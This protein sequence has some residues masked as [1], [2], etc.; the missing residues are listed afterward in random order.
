LSTTFENLID[1]TLAE[2][3]GQTSDLEQVTFLTANINA[4]DLTLSVDDAS[5]VSRGLIEIDDELM[6]V[7]RVDPTANQVYIAPF[8][9]GYRSTTAATHTANTMVTDNPRFPRSAIKSKINE[10]IGE[11]YPEIFT[12]KTDESNTSNPVLV[13]YPAPSDCDVILE[14]SWKTI[15]PTREWLPVKRYRLNTSA[16]STA[17][18]TGRSVDIGDPMHPGQVIRIVYIAPAAQFVN[19][20]DTLTSVGLDDNAKDILLYGACYRL[21]AGLE[22]ARMQTTTV[23]QSTRDQ[24]V[25]SGSAMKGS[26][27]YY[28]LFQSRLENERDRLLKI[29]RTNTHFTR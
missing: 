5:Q 24:L 25:P 17:F 29:H 16:D 6:W 3:H 23:Q 27:F 26:Q 14:L 4:T 18:P 13:T 2:L 20:S 15:G 8:G 11:I 1:E 22:V 28:S 19:L 12:V 21:V 9:R 10:T 7:T